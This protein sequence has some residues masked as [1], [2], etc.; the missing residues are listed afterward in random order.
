MPVSVRRSATREGLGDAEVRDQRVTVLGQE[1]VLGLDVAV[2]DSVP[3]RIVQSPGD[4]RSNP[5]RFV[6][7]ELP[8]SDHP[9]AE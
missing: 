6:H 4:L 8:S 9:D 7:R 1:D 2:D 3:V 5:Y